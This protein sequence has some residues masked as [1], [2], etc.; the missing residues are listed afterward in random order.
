V[1]I[2]VRLLGN[3]PSSV[4]NLAIRSPPYASCGDPTYRGTVFT[5]FTKLHAIRSLP[6][7]VQLQL[8]GGQR[9]SPATK[10]RKE[11][12]LCVQVLRP[13]RVTPLSPRI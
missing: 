10:I 9:A 2:I 6:D 12:E 8:P 4:Y 11:T 13:R 7:S 3:A 1:R 5:L